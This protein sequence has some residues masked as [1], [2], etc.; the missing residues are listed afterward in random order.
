MTELFGSWTP[1]IA[2]VVTMLALLWLKRRITRALQEVSM[3]LVNDHEMPV[4]NR[5]LVWRRMG[6]Q[7]AN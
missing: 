3:R 1:L 7:G 4:N 5:I 2:L 6:G